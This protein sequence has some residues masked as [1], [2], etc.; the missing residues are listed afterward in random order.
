MW[1]SSR[2]EISF[3][4]TR[5]EELEKSSFGSDNRTYDNQNQISYATFMKVR[6]LIVYVT[7]IF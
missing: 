7:I 2:R 1:L 3:I 6:F 4:L 5:F